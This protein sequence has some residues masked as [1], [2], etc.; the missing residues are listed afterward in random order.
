MTDQTVREK[1]GAHVIPAISRSWK[2]A[3][4]DIRGP[5]NHP[6][7]DNRC[8]SILLQMQAVIHM[9][10]QEAGPLGIKYMCDQTQHM[11]IAPDGDACF[12]FK[13]LDENRQPHKNDTDR[14][15]A[16]YQSLLFPEF[17]TLVAGLVPAQNWLSYVGIYLCRPNKKGDGNSWEM[18]ITNKIILNEDSQDTLTLLESPNFDEQIEKPKTKFTPKRNHGK[19]IGESS[20][21][22]GSGGRGA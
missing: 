1:F 20:E 18:E 22:A 2:R 7:H 9:R 12:I 19:D 16:L 21:E 6:G 5:F 17:P 11:F 13:K 14:S 15:K 4:D 8:R 3:W 10:D